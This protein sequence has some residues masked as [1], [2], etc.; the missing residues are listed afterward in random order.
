MQP[1][2]VFYPA[3]GNVPA[4]PAVVF[5]SFGKNE[6]FT[7]G[8]TTGTLAV[9]RMIS[10]GDHTIPFTISAITAAKIT[11]STPLPKNFIANTH[12]Y[13]VPKY[14][15]W[16]ADKNRACKC[17]ARFSGYDCS[18]RKCPRGDDPLT[19]GQFFET[20]TIN[21]GYAIS[22]AAAN[23][24]F[25]NTVANKV[26]GSFKLIFTDYFGEKWTTAA[27]PVDGAT[28]KSAEVKAALKALPNDVV[29]DVTVTF[30][31]RQTK[32]I[33]YYVKFDGGATPTSTG[34]S[35]DLPDMVCDG[36]ELNTRMESIGFASGGADNAG[37]ATVSGIANTVAIAAANLAD[38]TMKSNAI[39]VGDIVSGYVT[40]GTFVADNTVTSITF[41]AGNIVDSGGATLTVTVAS[42]ALSTATLSATP[43]NLFIGDAV[44]IDGQ[45]RTVTNI[46]A[47]VVTID[48]DLSAAVA[49]GSAITSAQMTHFSISGACA[50][51]VKFKI[52]RN[53]KGGVQCT[54][55]DQAQIFA[56]S[57]GWVALSADLA[58]GGA[59]LPGFV[60]S[61]T[62][63]AT[64]LSVGSRIRLFDTS[65]LNSEV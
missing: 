50:S 24:V 14:E 13:L 11:V 57:G 61:A 21:I 1:K 7:T 26:T 42:G 44:A 53:I 45:Q 35:G 65:N 51:C 27:I 49:G 34:N 36:A 9:G 23:D 32:A 2:Q 47:A 18:E 25:A 31:A 40:A 55:T 19:V 43:V 3:S 62:F 4:V 17:D 41:A 10:V 30:L 46:A 16:D 56:P 5:G 48:S 58:A 15:L 28:D 63:S 60:L 6:L 12:V 38:G 22:E 59:G 52:V 33:R 37:P 39:A 20:Q 64:E 54:A 8:D 29:Q